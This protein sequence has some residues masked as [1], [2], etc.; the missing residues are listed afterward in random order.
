M[1]FKENNSYSFDYVQASL[2]NCSV[3]WDRG[4]KLGYTAKRNLVAFQE[5]NY[6]STA[7]TFIYKFF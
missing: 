5:T 2:S 7:Y 4:G 3:L 6:I 1:A